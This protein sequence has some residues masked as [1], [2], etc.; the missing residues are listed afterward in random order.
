MIE[1]AFAFLVYTIAGLLIAAA[2]VAVAILS[3]IMLGN[4]K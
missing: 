2:V 3:L 4:I 1:G